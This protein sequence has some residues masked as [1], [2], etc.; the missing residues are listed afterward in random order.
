MPTKKIPKKPLWPGVDKVIAKR[1]GFESEGQKYDQG[2]L[3]YDLI[4]ME[5]MDELAKILTY[6]ATKYGKPSRW[7]TVPDMEN[8]YFAA[9]MRHLSRNRQ[10]EKLDPES[11]Y[12]HLSHALCNVVFLLWKELQNEPN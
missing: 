12:S 1:L 8:R 5:C 2:K 9:L 3:M 4:P 10:G 11:G 6:G 7:E